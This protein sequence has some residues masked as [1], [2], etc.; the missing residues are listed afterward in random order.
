VGIS[1]Q[2][3]LTLLQKVL[4]EGKIVSKDEAMFIC[5][6][7]HHRK[8]KLAVNLSTQ[9]WQSWIDTNAKGRSI[10]ALFKR[11]QV[12]SNYFA[13]LS[14]IVKLPK[15]TKL[16]D[17][18]EKYVSLPYEFKRLTETHKDFSYTQAINYLK[19]RGIKSYDIERY[20]IGYCSDGD[21]SGRIIVPSYDQDNKLNYFIA[22]DFTGNAYLKYKNPP[23][24]KD[25]VVFENQIDYS[26]PI[27]LCE[28]VFDAIAI[29]RNAIAL[30]GKNIPSKLKIKMIENKVSEVYVVLDEDAIKNAVAITETL[31]NEDIK[32]RFVK[33]GNE[34]AADVGFRGMVEKLR[35]TPIMGFDAL[36]KQ[37][38]CMS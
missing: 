22:R 32:V 14:K 34:D 31:L 7:S 28:G 20:D 24:S 13:E 11:L 3:L 1:E 16:V 18:E 15:S 37:K 5:P 21:Y 25:V 35:N 27:V 4:G 38:L 9:R 30:L 8:P 29:R 6:F 36:M 19:N 12:P 26:E 33:M 10:F 23:V 17:A 2:K